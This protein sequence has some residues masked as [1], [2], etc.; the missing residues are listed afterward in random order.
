MSQLSESLKAPYLRRT[1]ISFSNESSLP[2]S[3]FLSMIFTANI[4][5][6][7]SLLSA[8]L[9]SENAPLNKGKYNI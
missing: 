5:P 7:F 2:F 9:T 6:G 1:L 3:A 4:W 8:S